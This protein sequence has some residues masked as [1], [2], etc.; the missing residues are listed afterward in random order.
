MTASF[1]VFDER[2]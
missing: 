2:H 1:Q